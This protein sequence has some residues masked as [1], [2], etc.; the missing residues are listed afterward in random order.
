MLSSWGRRRLQALMKRN[1]KNKL[2]VGGSF[3]RR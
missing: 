3:Q 2:A 1:Q